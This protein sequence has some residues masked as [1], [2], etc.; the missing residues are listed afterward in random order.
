MNAIVAGSMVA[1]LGEATIYAMEQVYLGKKTFDDIDWL[2]KLLESKLSQDLIN[3]V[4]E[5][6][7]IVSK[8]GVKLEI[9]DIAQIITELFVSKK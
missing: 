9:K 1:A 6:A 5:I 2:K 8:K 3:R 7:K 4:V